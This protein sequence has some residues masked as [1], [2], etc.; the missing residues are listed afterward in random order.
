MRLVWS[1]LMGLFLNTLVG[2]SYYLPPT[3]PCISNEEFILA[4][5]LVQQTN[6]QLAVQNKLHR[7]A[8]NVTK[9]TWPLRPKAGFTAP[10][11][12]TLL[13]Y[14]DHDEAFGSTIDYT[15]GH[16]TYDIQGYNHA[17]TDIGLWPFPWKML[18][19]GQ[20]E[21]I[22]AAD[23][24][25][26][27]K[28]DGGYDRVCIWG[29]GS[30]ANYVIITHADGSQTW[31][32][33]LK[34]GSVTSLEPGAIVK[35][36]DYL[37]LVASSG[38]SNYPHL[39][40][41]VRD[42][43][44]Q[45]ID[46]YSGPCND[47]NAT[48]WWATQPN[49]WQPALVKL[50]TN[51]GPPL[52]NACP[53]PE[54]THEQTVFNPG[55]NV[56][57]IGYTRDLRMGQQVSYRII[58][59]NGQIFRAWTHQNNYDAWAEYKYWFYELPF[60]SPIGQ[61]T[62]E[63]IF[64]QDTFNIKFA[65][66]TAC[67]AAS[68][69][70]VNKK[71]STSA[72]LS[73][74]SQAALSHM[75][76]Y[77]PANQT[78]WSQVKLSTEQTT[79]ISRLLP[80]TTYEWKLGK[81]CQSG[82]T[83]WVDGPDFI[84]EPWSLFDPELVLVSPTPA[85]PFDDIT[86]EIGGFKKTGAYLKASSYLVEKDNH[87][88]VQL[89]WAD[90]LPDEAEFLPFTT[91]INLG[92]FLEGYYSL[93]FS[94][95]NWRFENL[96]GRYGFEVRLCPIPKWSVEATSATTAAIY[97]STLNETNTQ[98]FRHR[99]ESGPWIYDTLIRT[100]CI[101]PPCPILLSSNLE[102]RRNQLFLKNLAPCT[103]YEV[104]LK[105]NCSVEEYTKSEAIT[106]S[107]INAPCLAP[108]DLRL[109]SS[110]LTSIQ[111]RWEDSLES[112][113]YDSYLIKYRKQGQQKW[114]E[115]RLLDGSTTPIGIHFDQV[116]WL[117]GCLCSQG[118]FTRPILH[119]LPKS[120]LLKGL[121]PCTAYE[122]T[123]QKEC[124][125]GAS[126][127]T[128]VLTFSTTCIQSPENYAYTLFPHST[129]F[130][131]LLINNQDFSDSCVDCQGCLRPGYIKSLDTLRIA[132]PQQLKI[133]WSNSPA[134]QGHY[135]D[136]AG[137]VFPFP[138][139]G[140]LGVYLDTNLDG[141]FDTLAYEYSGPQPGGVANLDLTSHSNRYLS[142]RLVY[143]YLDEP[144]STGRFHFGHVLDFT[145]DKGN[146]SSTTT[147]VNRLNFNINPNPAQ[148]FTVLNFNAQS[149]LL[150]IFITNMHGKILKTQFIAPGQTNSIITLDGLQDGV[151]LVYL[152]SSK[153][154]GV[155]KLVIKK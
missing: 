122:F 125:D 80:G 103:S 96:S 27:A 128:P 123:A 137:R 5:Q 49:Y 69:L 120:L 32:W 39:H 114:E 26:S 61:W 57:F 2:Q 155:Q 88:N 47:A 16:R 29:E 144:F 151:Y 50:S 110:D 33:H 129:G 121:W 17:G 112:F 138:E 34:E 148:H 106:T 86:L 42:A 104:Q 13:Q 70:W 65:I 51:T 46:P 99:K 18:D 149:E 105:L 52:F 66:S 67:L 63:A 116:D 91:T 9:L 64:L 152:L 8:R 132:N 21:V 30:A 60:N 113:P 135:T 31:Y 35:R 94:G 87:L 108:F 133:E 45:V 111:L 14:V 85:T 124:L 90:T 1:G 20:I 81:I 38:F 53:L 146:T 41:E 130:S 83:S 62:F 119:P 98:I 95:S 89:T 76:L 3:K 11:Y 153:A 79:N 25:I 107:C 101:F 74:S 127:A 28:Y 117:Q 77:R 145:L 48:S 82:D 40:F 37:G 10:S 12:F 136:L 78:I 93:G 71:T 54:T 139:S 23:G 75:L 44:G 22:A 7:H 142:M 118:C 100:L 72:E 73:W 143:T 84:T 134:G 109:E 102:L 6:A 15:C 92:K 59:P 150:K 115:V 19:E 147:P 141:S 55:Q 36:G 56:F 126:P 24:F 140:K 131:K 68:D 97:T 154:A 58:N 43:N 4:T